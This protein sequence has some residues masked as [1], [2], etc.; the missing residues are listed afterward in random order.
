[1]SRTVVVLG[2]TGLVGRTVLAI[3]EERAF[4]LARVRALASDRGTARSVRFR[5]AD[6]AVEP[7]TAEAFRGA[8]LAL[9][10]TAA[11][12]SREWEPV[13]RAAGA[14]IVDLSSAFRQ[15]DDVPLVVPEVNGALLET[16]PVLVANPNCVAVPVAMALKPLEA[17]G[18]LERVVVA[19]YQSV[20]GAGAEAL[21]ELETGIRAGLEGPP[22]PRAGGL[23]AFAYN[24]VPWIDRFDDDGW[25]FEERKIVN[26]TRKLLARPE[27]S[28]IPTAVRVPV[29]VG[30]AAAIVATFDR[31]VAV[32]AARERWRAFAGVRVVDE[33]AAG[34]VPTP[35]AAA[36]GD[37]VLVGRARRAGDDACTLAFFVAA[38]NLRKGAALN[39]VQVAERLVG[40]PAAAR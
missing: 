21:A 3:L 17:L 15:C 26:E 23:P 7:A 13:A 11:E 36:G 38:D 8:E 33:P 9:F 12:P 32:E 14:R 34:R 29:R 10:A 20:S 1:M 18:R 27:L 28:V 37:D 25:T 40:A 5:G 22:P 30:H 16:R 35:L 19:S 31:A 6:V 2:A 4:P 39:A 24:V